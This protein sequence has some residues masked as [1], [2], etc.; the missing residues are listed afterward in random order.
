MS[1]AGNY[2]GLQL[3]TNLTGIT[4]WSNQYP[5]TNFFKSSRNWITHGPKGT[6]WSTKELDKL[7]LDKQGYPK[8]LEGGTFESV[9][10]F[11]PNPA[12]F[13][14]YVV[15]YDGEG[16]IDVPLRGKVN[17]AESRPGRLVVDAP[18]DR[19]FNLRISETDPNGTGDY[20]RN[21]RVVPEAYLDIYKSQP[22][23]PDFLKSLEGM[24]VLRFMDW[25]HTNGSQQ[26]EWGNRPQMDD[27]SYSGKGAPVEVMVAL[28]NETGI[29]P[30]FNMPHMATDEYVRNF[31]R[32]VKENLDPS[33]K[34]HVELSNEVWNSQFPQSWYAD[35]Q[36]GGGTKEK[37]Q[38]FGQRTAEVTQI[39][40]DVFG[41]ESD[42]VIGVLG[43]QAANSSTAEQALKGVQALGL[44]YDEVGIDTVS[45]A[46]YFRPGLK[47][48][49]IKL[50]EKW[51]VEKGQDYALDQLFKEIMQGGVLPDDHP[52]GSIAQAGARIEKY[53]DLVNSE[54]L[55]LSAYEGGQHVAPRHNGM[56][57]NQVLVDLFIA[58]N[59]DP[60]MGDAYRQYF[61]MWNELT[62]GSLF[63]NFSDIS[64]PSKWGSWGV[65]ESLYEEGAPK[66]DAI[67]DILEAISIGTASKEN[68]VPES[69]PKGSADEAASDDVED[70]PEAEDAADDADQSKDSGLDAPDEGGPEAADTPDDT[71]AE[72]LDGN[73]DAGSSGRSDLIDGNTGKP[74]QFE[75][76]DL[77]L[78]GYKREVVKGSGAS[79]GEQ[80]SL[81]G[82]SGGSGTASGVF[83]GEA[84]TYQVKVHY[85]D[86]NDG[87]STA[88]VTIN[89]D[90]QTLTFDQDLPNNWAKP[91]SLT[92]QVTHQSV[93]L[94]PGD[95]FEIEAQGHRGEFARFDAV[96]FSPVDPSSPQAAD[97]PTPQT[98]TSTRTKAEKIEFR[99]AGE[100][101]TV[102]GG[103]QTS[104]PD[105][106]SGSDMGDALTTDSKKPMFNLI[107]AT[108]GSSALKGTTGR[109]LFQIGQDGVVAMIQA[110]E[111]GEDQIRIG[112]G[113]GSDSLAILQMGNK[114]LVGDLATG[115]VF[116]QLQGVSAQALIAS[117]DETFQTA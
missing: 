59:R 84:G 76:E 88:T 1:T 112:S 15:L 40:D 87:Q 20:I 34:P 9:S 4:D 39:W 113:Q 115:A 41:G 51:V 43:A 89:G 97:A 47:D 58:A 64:V 21:I 53:V 62:D 45:I 104:G 35:E 13:D 37:L 17:E 72:N 29:G 3:G 102:V 57:N 52:E 32:Y 36:G 8:S 74:I 55:A 30:W 95:R 85:F 61:Q 81:K 6:G 24:K 14:R 26:S 93:A 28:A 100:A 109:D 108:E 18:G 66:F 99:D 106:L 38:W 98:Q 60:R 103:V 56:E 2:A 12:K 107:E 91:E 105:A 116:A 110:F 50:M 33:L 63:A 92:S 70:G 75:A 10:T 11:I 27:A 49:Q 83:D 71:A 69:G 80:I 117:A 5:F 86:E 65:R 16:T 46:P 31:A 90:S 7:D 94:K 67:Q 44:T 42:R 68:T 82:V 22:F 73:T 114:T 25:M 101:T 79:G 54:G 78:V 19:T 23:N 48:N 96:E 111:I 77:E